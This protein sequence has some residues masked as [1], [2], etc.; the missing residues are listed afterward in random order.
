VKRIAHV[1]VSLALFGALLGAQPPE[2]R[3]R[4]RAV[5]VYVDAGEQPL[6]AYQFELA[7][8]TGNVKI[9]GIE[10]GDHAA[11]HEP[12]YYDP[13]AIQND[14]VVLAAFTTGRDVP[15]GRTRVARVHVMITGE[16][17]PEY[18]AR[19]EAAASPEGQRIAA[20]ATIAKGEEE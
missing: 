17:E 3:V 16:A 19:L 7:A 8:E 13:K 6:A 2:P 4:F 15:R 14:R 9:V 1:A 12:P 11:F 5:D 18:A 10:G 20:T